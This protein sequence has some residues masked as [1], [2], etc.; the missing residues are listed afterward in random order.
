MMI[1]TN[2]SSYLSLFLIFSFTSLNLGAQNLHNSKIKWVDFESAEK[3]SKSTKTPKK[4]MVDLYTDNCG[5][6]KKMDLSTFQ[7]EFIAHYLNEKFYPIRF[8]AQQRK[9]VSFNDQIFKLD[10][11]GYHELAIALS[12]GDLSMPTLVFLDE[13]NQIIQPIPGYQN[14]DDLE[15]I[16]HY[17]ANDIYL[18]QPWYEFVRLYKPTNSKPTIM[19]EPEKITIEAKSK[20]N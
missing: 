3:A 15:R 13:A 1:K 16:L 4:I 9:D 11:S 2:H 5:W 12:L 14:V 6:C 8:N 7:N 18:K 19:I 17:F 20:K 10:K